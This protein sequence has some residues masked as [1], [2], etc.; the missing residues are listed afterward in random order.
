[1]CQECDLRPWLVR[2]LLNA[3]VK[4]PAAGS[5]VGN[6]SFSAP[7]MCVP[8]EGAKGSWVTPEPSPPA[9]LGSEIP[10]QEVPEF[11]VDM[12]STE[13]GQRTQGRSSLRL[14]NSSARV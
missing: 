1:M 7:G 11:T 8:Q 3:L 10:R 12:S 6:V 5:S 9:G 2:G 4:L 13:S 14:G